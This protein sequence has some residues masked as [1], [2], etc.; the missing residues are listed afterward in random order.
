MKILKETIKKKA[1]EAGFELCGMALPEALNP[2]GEHYREMVS[3][4]DYQDHPYLNRDPE[5]R[6]DPLLVMPSAGTVISLMMNYCSPE[7]PPVEDNFIVSRYAWGRDY[8][9]VLKERMKIIVDFLKTECGSKESR[10][11]VDSAPLMEKAWA[12]RCGLGWQGKNTI[13][14]NPRKGSWFFIGV[15]LTDLKMEPDFPTGDQCGNCTK[16]IDA[17]PTGALEPYKLNPS[18]C[19]SNLTI[20]KTIDVPEE[21]YQKFGGRIYGCDICQDACPYNRFAVPSADPDFAVNPALMKMNKRKWVEL[22]HEDFD[23]IFSHSP[24]KRAGYDRLMHNIQFENLK[25]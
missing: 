13:M 18:L 20:E 10:A 22:T 5:K 11:F 17:C 14:I 2:E 24:V 3:R 9:E 15:I 6:T 21:L 23:A 8:H 12:A 4:T 16:C 25:I 7:K 19:I 1:A